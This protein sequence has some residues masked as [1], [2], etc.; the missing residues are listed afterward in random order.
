MN[1]DYKL[2][3]QTKRG[4]IADCKY[5][6]SVYV[7]N[8]DSVEFFY[9]LNPENLFYMRSL[10]KP[11]QA[12]ILFNSSIIDDIGILPVEIAIMAGSHAGSSQHIKVLKSIMNKYQIKVSDLELSPIP[13]LD[14]R[15]FNSRITKLHNNCSGKH[16]MMLI[17][18]KYY[19]FPL[20]DYCN[21]N[22]PIQKMILKN[23]IELSQ[24]QSK[25]FSFDGCG[26][27][28]WAITATGI[29][30]AYYNLINNGKYD[31]LINSILKYPDYFGGYDRLDSDIIKLSKGRLFSKVG[32]GGFIIVYNLAENKSL[33]IKRDLFSAKL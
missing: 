22:H 4:D 13:P 7:S 21:P 31:Y 16:L 27:P 18:S 10:A 15:N 14:T 23:Q 3:L 29:I 33:L 26:T 28:L 19:N 20:K 2:V 9:G 25:D 30:R 17:A 12:S 6:A 32:A 1:N 11:L 24:Y 5:Y 8:K